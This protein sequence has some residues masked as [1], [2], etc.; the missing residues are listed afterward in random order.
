MTFAGQGPI[1]TG[2]TTVVTS[3]ARVIGL[4]FDPVTLGPVVGA[5]LV[6]VHIPLGNGLAIVTWNI[7]VTLSP[8]GIVPMPFVT[9]SPAN[10]A[11][12]AA[13]LT[14]IAGLASARSPPALKPAFETERASLSGLKAAVRGVADGA[15]PPSATFAAPT[16]VLVGMTEAT[17]FWAS[18][19]DAGLADDILTGS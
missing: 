18:A 13:G 19:P 14:I 8:A 16:P 4:K 3:G 7:M 1:T 17:A 11:A 5:G 2:L 10:G 12:A 6:T 9:V 15:S